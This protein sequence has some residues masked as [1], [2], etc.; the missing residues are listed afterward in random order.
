M[1]ASTTLHH[2]PPP[3]DAEAVGDLL[4]V[5]SMLVKLDEERRAYLDDW[6]ARQSEAK[7]TKA[8]LLRKL[9]GEPEPEAPFVRQLT[10]PGTGEVVR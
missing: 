9:R 7:N 10:M 3:P 6:K 4:A 8:K 2:R 5:E 1:T